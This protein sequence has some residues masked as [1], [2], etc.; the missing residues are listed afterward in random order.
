[1]D[2]IPKEKDIE[3]NYTELVTVTDTSIIP[4]TSKGMDISE[5]PKTNTE[6]VPDS[7]INI[8]PSGSDSVVNK[9]ELKSPNYSTGN[10]G[11]TIKANGDVEFNNGNFR[12]D[13]TGASGTFTGAVNATAINIPDTVTANSFHV[14]SAGN[15]WWGSTAIGNSKAKVLSTGIATFLDVNLNER[16]K[17]IGPTEDIQD[18]IDDLG[19]DGGTLHLTS[20]V[21]TLSN[22]IVLNSSTRLE[23]DSFKN[24]ILNFNGGAYSIK[25]IGDTPY[26]TGTITSITSGINVTGSGTSWSTN[27]TAGQHLFLGTRWYKIGSVTDDTHLVLAEGY[28][29]SLSMPGLAYQ[30]CDVIQDSALSNLTV[31][32]S[33]NSGIYLTRSREI[34]IEDVYT[35]GNGNDGVTILDTMAIT[36]NRFYCVANARDGFNITNSGYGDW[37]SIPSIGNGR[38]GFYIN[39]IKTIPMTSSAASANADSGFFITNSQDFYMIAEAQGNGVCG[40]EFDSNNNNI[41]MNGILIQGN[42]SDGILM[43]A[44]TDNCKLYGSKIAYN[45]GYGINI[46]ASTCDSNII[47]TNDFIGNSSGAGVDSGLGTVIR[48]NVGWAD[49]LISV[50]STISFTAAAGEDIAAG[51]AVKIV[52]PTDEVTIGGDSSTE[53]QIDNTGGT[54]VT[55]VAR[56]YLVG[57]A[58]KYV[59]YAIFYLKKTGSPG[60]L[61][62]NLRATSATGTIIATG[63]I[64]EANIPSSAGEA[65]ITFTNLVK[66]TASTAYYFELVPATANSTNYVSYYGEAASGF[67][68]DNFAYY[69]GGWVYQKQPSVYTKAGLNDGIGGT[70]KKAKATTTAESSIFAGFANNTVSSGGNVIVN[71][72]GMDTNQSSLSAGVTYYL[73]DTA[74]V[75][76][77]TAGT[78]SKKVGLATTPTNIIIKNEN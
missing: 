73:S 55:K 74:G 60:N 34:E 43:S 65:T 56:K 58:D 27:V 2:I 18:A 59:N 6:A 70:I 67:T 41:M 38:Y 7:D 54:P 11:W 63:T 46:G 26:T 4:N 45:G 53:Y 17:I 57:A 20:G 21:Y 3:S 23:G 1:M 50:A 52:L 68:G 61:T 28:G 37:T 51:N 5:V 72:S 8:I 16:I 10:A 9:G 33:T 36:T 47:T 31:T 22:D 14:D 77:V 49:N 24:T 42:T 71:V 35:V 15:A 44:T 64:T 66:L 40:I 48:G 30:I 75:I 32:G 39:N 12:G 62:I 76:S 19:T 78:I 25:I 29:D 13:I 69:A